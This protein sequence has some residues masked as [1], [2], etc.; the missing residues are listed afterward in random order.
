MGFVS[1]S[2]LAVVSVS[3]TDNG[4]LFVLTVAAFAGIKSRPTAGAKPVIAHFCPILR[5]RSPLTPFMYPQMKT[6]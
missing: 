2:R 1:K 3:S 4:F 6:S 5:F